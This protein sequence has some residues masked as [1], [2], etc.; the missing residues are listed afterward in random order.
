LDYDYT[1][2]SNLLQLL[3]EWPLNITLSPIK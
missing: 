2:L 1:Y 3:M